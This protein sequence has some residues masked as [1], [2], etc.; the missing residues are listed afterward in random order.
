MPLKRS[1]PR[2][3][4]KFQSA[5]L[6]VIAQSGCGDLGINNVAKEAGADK[7]LIYRYF[8]D[9]IGLLKTVATSRLWLPSSEDV[10]GSLSTADQTAESRLSAIQRAIVQHVRED[11]TAHQLLRWRKAGICPICDQFTAEWIALWGNLADALGSGLSFGERERWNRA[12]QLLAL[13]VEAELCNEPVSKDCLNFISEE[14]TASASIAEDSPAQ[15][16][17]TPLPTNLL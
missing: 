15:A 11:E 2:T 7:V 8:G 1:R 3:E 5:V 14:L 17:E 4:E 6:S 12:C 10:L 13:M 16:V 9:F